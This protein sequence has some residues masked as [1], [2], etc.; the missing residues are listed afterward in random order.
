VRVALHLGARHPGPD[1]DV[2]LRRLGARIDEHLD[3]VA[4]RP[5]GAGAPPGVSRPPAPRGG[6]R[7]PG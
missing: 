2:A 1:A 3:E 5:V 7:T 6:P 4:A